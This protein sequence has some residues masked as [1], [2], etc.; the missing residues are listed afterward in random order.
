[1]KADVVVV[2]GGSSKQAMGLN[3][4]LSLGRGSGGLRL[5]RAVLTVRD[6]RVVG[7][8]GLRFVLPAG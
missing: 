8:V 3:Q 5:V 2:F 7:S 4:S 6:S 1:V